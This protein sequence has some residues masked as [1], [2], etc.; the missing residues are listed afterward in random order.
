MSDEQLYDR[1]AQIFEQ[2]R[3]QVARTVNTAMV[4]AYWLIG[5]E[6]VEVEQ[7]GPGSRGLR[8]R[9][10]RAAFNPPAN[11]L[12]QRLQRRQ[13]PQDAAVLSRVSNRFGA[14]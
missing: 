2:A 7:A 6:I 10:H 8:R 11:R 12:R 4:Q 3:S 13:P 1:V 14:A 9:D 5:R